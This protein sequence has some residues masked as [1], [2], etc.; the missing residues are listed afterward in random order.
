MAQNNVDVILDFLRRNRFARA[1]AALLGELSNRP[2]LSKM[3]NDSRNFEKEDEEEEEEKAVGKQRSSGGSVSKELI[4]KEIECR[5]EKKFGSDLYS[6]KVDSS[7]GTLDFTNKDS[8]GSVT[9]CFSELQIL[10]QGKKHR[11]VGD[12][13]YSES[14][15]S[16]EEKVL[17]QGSTSKTNVDPKFGEKKEV[18]QESKAF[19][20]YSK[21]NSKD[22]AWSNMKESTDPSLDPWKDCSVKTVFPAPKEDG[23][24]NRKEGKKKAESSD[25]A[26]AMKQ[27]M[28]EFG[29]ALFFGKSQGISEQ[30]NIVSFDTPLLI[31]NHKEE[32]PRLP[33]VKLKSED[34][35]ANVHWEEKFDHHGSGP[36][37]SS[38]DNTF[39]IGS[40][41]DVPVG[42]EINSAGGKRTVGN[43]WLSVSQ[44]ITEDTSDLVSGFA[45][46]GDGLSELID[47]PN[48]YWDSDEYDDDDDIGYMRQPIEDETWFLA[49]EI[50]YPSD[51]E[52]GTGLGS[53]PD[54]QDRG[55]AKDEER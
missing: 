20:V 2:D 21:D 39:L 8:G 34:K 30:K 46:V 12:L 17:W 19:G 48:E 47:Y 5:N 38:L 41:L 51:N 14:S 1:E 33:P 25:N 9:S 16:G 37:L 27:Q 10:E 44:G 11:G 52:R 28:D 26:V 42:Q 3:S 6:W 15:K 4:V 7:N 23:S 18:E 49:H 29:K 31:E 53:V 32:L 50:D 36:K 55:P 13:K 45:T 24:E 43:S 40:F 22:N 54:Q 35:S